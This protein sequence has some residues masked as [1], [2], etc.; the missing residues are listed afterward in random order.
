MNKYIST[1]DAKYDYWIE[2]IGMFKPDTEAEL[3]RS[4]KAA[5]TA[6]DSMELKQIL[7]GMKVVT[8]IY[9][10]FL[11]TECYGIKEGANRCYSVVLAPAQHPTTEKEVASLRDE[12]KPEYQYKISAVSLED[13][14]ERTLQVC[15]EEDKAPFLYFKDRY[16]P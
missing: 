12:L 15:P 10:N 2:K 11:L 14:V 8:Q 1:K 16:I 9:R 5:K 6:K 7:K 13:F 4:A 3:I